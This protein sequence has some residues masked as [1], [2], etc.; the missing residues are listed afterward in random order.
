MERKQ[1]LLAL[2]PAKRME[3]EAQFKR[4]QSRPEVHQAK[5]ADVVSPRLRNNNVGGGITW[6]NSS[7]SSEK[8]ENRKS[9]TAP[10]PPSLARPQIPDFSAPLVPAPLRPAPPPSPV[11]TRRDNKPGSNN[12]SPNQ[13][14]RS[15]KGKRKKKYIYI[16]IFSCISSGQRPVASLRS[17]L[18]SPRS[19]EPASSPRPMA[20]IAVPRESSSSPRP[21]TSPRAPPSPPRRKLA[22]QPLMSQ[23]QSSL[24]NLS[25]R[26]PPLPTNLAGSLSLPAGSKQPSSRPLASPR[27]ANN[28]SNSNNINISNNMNNINNNTTN[29]V[30]SPRSD[31]R[32]P[33]PPPSFLPR[34]PFAVGRG[35]P[36]PPR[37]N[38][39]AAAVSRV[40]LPRQVAYGHGT[41]L[42]HIQ[43]PRQQ[44]QH[45]QQQQHHQQQHQ[46]HHQQHQ[47][48]QPFL[49]AAVIGQSFVAQRAE[50]HSVVAGTTVMVLARPTKNWLVISVGA[51]VGAIP[52]GCVRYFTPS[53]RRDAQ[54]FAAGRG[55]GRGGATRW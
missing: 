26:L 12:A 31:G 28:N 20:S 37:N 44:H 48:Q 1:T 47:Q 14:P 5:R 50:Q 19:V 49:G 25:P 17:P 35:S 6:T 45:L 23:S 43:Q 18:S 2:P 15:P 21:V 13:S 10:R 32:P 36:M 24:P 53:H 41:N 30:V 16:Y 34:D 39:S 22:D 27:A 54:D 11:Q 42:P 3:Q 51:S 33:P 52:V 46:Q 9:N 40:V 7:T 29:T 55:A 8:V 4:L 38:Q